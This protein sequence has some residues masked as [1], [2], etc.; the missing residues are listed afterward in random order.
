MTVQQL[1]K[2]PSFGSPKLKSNE[3]NIEVLY[4]VS[5][6]SSYSHAFFL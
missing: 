5:Y 6:C 4:G 3:K 1:K 2:A